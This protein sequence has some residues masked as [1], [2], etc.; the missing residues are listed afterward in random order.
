M[1]VISTAV[2][3]SSAA[4]GF[5]KHK[6]DLDADSITATTL[7]QLISSTF[8]ITASAWSKTSF[9]L[10]MLRL[11]GPRARHLIWF[12]IVTVNLTKAVSGGLGWVSCT[13]LYKAW[14]PYAEGICWDKRAISNFNL[15]SGGK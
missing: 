2:T 4:H 13:P 11:S 8:S 7:L 3:T 14:E 15:F 10:T 12:I 5:G 6:W 9:A 1:L